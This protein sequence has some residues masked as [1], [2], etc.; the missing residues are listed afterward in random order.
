MRFEESSPQFHAMQKG[1][2]VTSAT[3]MCLG[4]QCETFR[5]FATHCRLAAQGLAAVCWTCTAYAA[6][7][8]SHHS[9]AE[10]KA[11]TS[12]QQAHEVQVVRLP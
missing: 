8:D 3:G 4:L 9:Q 2:H 11:G 1:L 10:C 12:S 5:S 6:Q 7:I